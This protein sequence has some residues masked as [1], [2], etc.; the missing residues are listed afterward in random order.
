MVPCNEQFPN[1]PEAHDRLSLM[2]PTLINP[3]PEEGVRRRAGAWGWGVAIGLG[4]SYRAGA[5][6]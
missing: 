4:R 2:S 6:L 3:T 5:Q 1:D